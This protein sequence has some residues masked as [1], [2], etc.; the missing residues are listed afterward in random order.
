MEQKTH[1]LFNEIQLKGH[2]RFQQRGKASVYFVE[3]L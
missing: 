1:E 3:K 2:N